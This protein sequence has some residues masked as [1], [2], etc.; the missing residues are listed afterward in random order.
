MTYEKYFDKFIKN[1]NESVIQYIPNSDAKDFLYEN[2]PRLFCPDEVV[3]ETFVYTAEKS[4][5]LV[6]AIVLP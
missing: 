1:D 5:V 6:H 4:A 3:E 2:A